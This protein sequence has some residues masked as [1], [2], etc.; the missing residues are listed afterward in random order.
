M[1]EVCAIMADIEKLTGLLDCCTMCPRNCR[2]N[3][4]AGEVGYCGIAR[5]AR[6]ASAEAHFGEESV[7][8]GAGGSGT[9]FFCGCN[10]RCIFCQNYEISQDRR[11][12]DVT[13]DQLAGIMLKLQRR[14][15]ANINLVTPSHLA[16][17]IAI[18]LELARQR[19][20][21]LPVVYNTG[22][23]DSVET[24][25][26]LEGLIDIYMPDMKYSDA[27]I[28]ARLSDAGNYP[29]VNRPAVKEM[30]RQVGDLKVEN[31][32]A[33]RGLLVRHL[34]L[35]EEMAGSFKVIDFLAEEISTETVINVMGQ[36]RPCHLSDKCPPVN[37]YPTQKE[38]AKVVKYAK[39]KHLNV[40]EK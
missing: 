7:L 3:R 22:G 29:E 30:H 16:A 17:Q 23:Y 6:I 40:L 8:V 33:T 35:P 21:E 26:A 38:I 27:E 12:R 9:I 15:V 2:V 25:R 36:Y 32:L 1:V 24:L 11:G 4:N 13:T 14:G 18:A 20:L 37:R 39:K 34:V 10:L 19:G 5:D 31:N 28:S